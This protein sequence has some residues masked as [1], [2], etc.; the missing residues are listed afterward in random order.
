MCQQ[1]LQV[2]AGKGKEEHGTRE[3]HGS[4]EESEVDAAM[5]LGIWGKITGRKETQIPGTTKLKGISNLSAT[6]EGYEWIRA[7]QEALHHP[8]SHHP[9]PLSL[10]YVSSWQ[11]I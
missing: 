6:N 2:A 10:A 7:P 11:S 4:V 8:L 9:A 1:R 5:G 3:E